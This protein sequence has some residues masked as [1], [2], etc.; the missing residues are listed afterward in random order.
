[1]WSALVPRRQAYGGD[2]GATTGVRLATV[3]MSAG[4]EHILPV[5]E[6]RRA[7]GGVG[8]TVGTWWMTITVIVVPKQKLQA[9]S[10]Q[11]AGITQ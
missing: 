7:S 3:L 1:M 6:L 4:P 11:A 8:P 5:C 9:L 2:P 10:L